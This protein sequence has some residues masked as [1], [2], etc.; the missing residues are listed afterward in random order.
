MT[1]TFDVVILGVGSGAEVLAPPLAE[2]GRRVA[3]VEKRL[4]GGECPYFACMPSKA[5]LHEAREGSDWATAVRRRDEVAEQRDDS[6][7]EERLTGLGIAVLRGH[8]VIDGPGRLKVG[9]REIGWTDLVINTGSV[10][11]VPP[12]DG[13]D[14]APTWTSDEALSSPDLPRRLTVLGGGPV[15]CELA[16]AYAALGSAVTLVEALDRLLAAEPEFVG[17]AL[18][19][20]LRDQGIDVRLGA[21]LQRVDSGVLQLADG[22]HVDT[23]R[24]LIAVGRRPA[25]RDIGL[26]SL[27]LAADGPLEVDNSC[28]VPGVDHVWAIGDVT[29]LAPFTHTANYQGRVTAEVLLGRPAA[30]DLRAIPRA[31]YTSPAVYAVGL[32]PD[33]AKQQGIDLAVDG[34]EVANT[35]RGFAENVSDG[36]RVELYADRAR[37]VL[38]GAAGIGMGADSWLA[39]TTLA[40]RA[41][42][43]LRLYADVVHAF[44]TWGEVL[45]PPLR[46]LAA[47]VQ[48]GRE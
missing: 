15:G 27:G 34:G 29:G 12:I 40:I 3:I 22:S 46:R 20:A 1:E 42:V 48:G 37:G 25:V 45:E 24:V 41:Q 4:L 43:P 9:D 33:T 21:S 36:G 5:L 13:L 8:G 38:V 18:A 44:P 6:A 35:A 28:R 39:E 2:A 26:E 47:E 16:Q 17:V 14:S 23:D 32:T 31:V 19:A 30:V 10:P 7:V 11:V